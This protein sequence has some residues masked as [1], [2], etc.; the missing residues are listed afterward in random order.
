[1]LPAWLVPGP[2][3]PWLEGLRESLLLLL[4][5]FMPVVVPGFT[6]RMESDVAPGPT[7]PWLEAPGAGWFC[8]A[9]AMAVAPNSDAT[10]MAE[11]ASLER[12][13]NSS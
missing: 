9:D 7:L 8:C 3:L 1:M 13:G 11:S 5:W 2:T 4:P 6:L 10:T 12:M